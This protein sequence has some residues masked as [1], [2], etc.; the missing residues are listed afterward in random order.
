M[1]TFPSS[2]CLSQDI[3]QVV[4][5]DRRIARQ[6]PVGPDTHA[7]YAVDD[8]G[9]IVL[10]HANIA[11]ARRRA[12]SFE[13]LAELR[14]ALSDYILV[15]LA[16]WGYIHHPFGKSLVLFGSSI[17]ED[18]HP[19]GHYYRQRCAMIDAVAGGKLVADLVHRRPPVTG[20]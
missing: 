19:R 5:A 9:E 14:D 10:G 4:A 18:L 12:D 7:G 16:G 1:L 20:I 15:A 3:Q 6:L 2:K 13:E 8:P 17:L 11:Q